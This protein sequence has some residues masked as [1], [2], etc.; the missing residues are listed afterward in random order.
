M[1]CWPHQPVRAHPPDQPRVP[2]G[3]AL[4]CSYLL[5]AQTMAAVYCALLQVTGGVKF[6]MM[7]EDMATEFHSTTLQGLPTDHKVPTITVAKGY[8]F[9]TAVR[10]MPMPALRL[11]ALALFLTHATFIV[12]TQVH[13][14][15]CCYAATL[16]PRLRGLACPSF[17]PFPPS[18]LA[19]ACS[20]TCHPPFATHR[21]PHP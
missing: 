17:P 7:D 16:L 5:S 18:H 2:R 9:A 1:R 3:R 6:N 8:R 19:P 4:W 15:A 10:S 12:S 13:L 14:P 20:P 11:A 21:A